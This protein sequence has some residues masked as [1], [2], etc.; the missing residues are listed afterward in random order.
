MLKISDAQNN[1]AVAALQPL[2]R[3]RKQAE[4]ARETFLGVT[5]AIGCKRHTKAGSLDPALLESRI[6]LEGLAQELSASKSSKADQA[7][8]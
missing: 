8:A 5:R 6:C 3:S 1:C 4:K 7:A 2:S